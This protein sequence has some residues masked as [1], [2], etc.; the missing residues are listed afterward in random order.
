MTFIAFAYVAEGN[1]HD[2]CL[3]LSYT[4]S[5]ARAPRRMA[6]RMCGTSICTASSLR[7]DR[8]SIFGP[9]L[10]S[11][12]LIPAF[13]ICGLEIAAGIEIYHTQSLRRELTRECART[14]MEETLCPHVGRSTLQVTELIHVVNHIALEI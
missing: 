7:S 14:V 10:S 9:I 6:C 12:S 13:L 8:R 3:S 4:R 5:C 11:R 1:E 2:S